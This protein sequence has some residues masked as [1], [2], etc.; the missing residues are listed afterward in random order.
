[1]TIAI[2]G[3]NAFQTRTELRKLIAAFVS[4]HGDIALEKIAATE[5]TLGQITGAIESLP[6]LA[7]KRWSS[8]M[9]FH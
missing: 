6:F 9:T 4:E 8:S 3:P 1:M 7:A 2:T 5:T